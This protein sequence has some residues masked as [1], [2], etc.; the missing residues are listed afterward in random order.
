MIIIGCFLLHQSLKISKKGNL[1]LMKYALRVMKNFNIEKFVEDLSVKFINYKV[2]VTKSINKQ[3]EHFLSL[4][5][6][7]VNAYALLRIRSRKKQKLQKKRWL[8]SLLKL[9]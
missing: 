7:V 6:S 8:F 9:N 3:F 1:T 2:E 4:L 5:A